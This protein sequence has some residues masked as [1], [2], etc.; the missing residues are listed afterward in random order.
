VSSLWAS[1][2]DWPATV[3]P[4]DTVDDPAGPFAGVLITAAGTLWVY[5]RGG[6]QYTSGIAV[7]VVAGEY[8]RF[9]IRRIG[10]TGTS[11]AT[12]VGLVGAIVKQGANA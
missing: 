12:C 11:G 7:P 6:P 2:Y 10:V 1:S 4:S 8:L 3:T 5:P 9:P